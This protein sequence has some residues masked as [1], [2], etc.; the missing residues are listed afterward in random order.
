MNIQ[1]VR[2]KTPAESA[3]IDMFGER[4]GALSGTPEV[5]AARD[6]AL[7][8]LK[9]NGLP[10]R[11]IE[12]WHYTDLRTLFKSTAPFVSSS[13]VKLRPVLVAGSSQLAVVNG[14]A[15]AAKAVSDVTVTLVRDM[16]HDGSIAGTMVT[17]GFDDAVG[18]INTAY[19]SDGW[20]LE[21]ADGTELQAP[22]ELQN[23]QFGGQSHVRFPA[24]FGKNTKATIIERQIGGTSETLSSSVSHVSV[25]DGADIIWVIVREFDESST[26]FSQFN[27]TIGAD[28][29]LTLYIVN[30][31]GHLVRQE[32]HV[33]VLGEDSDFEMRTLNLLSDKSHTD[34]TMTVGHLV[35][36][37]R[38]VE[39]VR[40]VVT[41]EARGVF[42]GMIKV[43]QI[44]Q[45]TDARMAC[46]TLLLSDGA[47]FDA[48]PELEIFA[49]DV[50]C[51][52][53]AT[54]TEIHNDHLFY[55]MARGI[56]EPVARGLLVKAFIAEIIE[57]LENESLVEAL[58][59]ILSD[60][61]EAHA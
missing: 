28:A 42:Q 38:S 26:Q 15:Q 13:D 55:L 16:L 56:P 9:N 44:A 27:A 12:S 5:L 34:V 46:N 22:L 18:Q 3:L 52:H 33:D 53:G 47:E 50:A 37:T 60:W 21:L 36:N 35:E 17:K 40:N 48:K 2:P 45:K 24:K 20:A 39:I 31:G 30:A 54:V 6:N 10:S 11:R 14:V 43:A 1:T 4:I 49:D 61:L 25:E 51:G 57:E 7:E 23:V 58:E 19:V 59:A 29:K 32:I 41:G 8:E